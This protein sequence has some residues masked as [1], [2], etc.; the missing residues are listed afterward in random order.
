MDWV[1]PETPLDD[2]PSA[3][4]EVSLD[5][6]L[7]EVLGVACG[8]WGLRLGADNVR[9]GRTIVEDASSLVEKTTKESSGLN[10]SAVAPVAHPGLG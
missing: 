4:I 3:V 1:R 9:R 8:A 7:G 5:A 6:T 10:P 2:R